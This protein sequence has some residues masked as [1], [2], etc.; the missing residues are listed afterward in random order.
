MQPSLSPRTCPNFL[1]PT[2][3]NAESADVARDAGFG[4]GGQATAATLVPGLQGEVPFGR[5]FE[6]GR[7]LHDLSLAIASAAVR[8]FSIHEALAAKQRERGSKSGAKFKPSV[9]AF[10]TLHRFAAEQRRLQ[11]ERGAIG[12]RKR[13]EDADLETGPVVIDIA[14]PDFALDLGVDRPVPT[15]PELDE[16][17]RAPGL[18]QIASLMRDGGEPLLHAFRHRP[19]ARMRRLRQRCCSGQPQQVSRRSASSPNHSPTLSSSPY[20][21]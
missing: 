17:I 7:D 21:S 9:L 10:R 5:E 20:V 16:V 12:Q 13:L 15:K 19:C 11:R 8:R 4:L 3:A 2:E 1:T 6:P 18:A 14:D